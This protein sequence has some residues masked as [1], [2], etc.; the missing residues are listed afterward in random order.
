MKALKDA[1]ALFNTSEAESNTAFQEGKAAYIVSGP[2]ML[3]TFKDA[4]GD[5]LL[6]A[7]HEQTEEQ[8][9]MPCWSHAGAPIFRT[10]AAQDSIH[11]GRA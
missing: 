1:G 9:T 2:W 8:K 10:M 5:E 4:L 11:K 7:R 6:Q 3:G